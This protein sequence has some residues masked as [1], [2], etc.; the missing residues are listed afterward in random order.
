[1]LV[2][3]NKDRRRRRHRKKCDRSMM[4]WTLKRP[5]QPKHYSFHVLV[6]WLRQTK[7]RGGENFK[8]QLPACAVRLTAPDF[9]CPSGRGRSCRPRPPT[10]AR[11][12]DGRGKPS[13][14]LRQTDAASHP[15]DGVPSIKTGVKSS[16]ACLPP[17]YPP[18]DEYCSGIDRSH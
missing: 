9:V 8:R 13:D 11:P 16:P 7:R 3:W 6:L 5:N 1:M 14:R 4:T 18:C 10:P 15:S 17:I 12:T 2:S